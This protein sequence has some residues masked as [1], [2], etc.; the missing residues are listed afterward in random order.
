MFQSALL[1]KAVPPPLPLASEHVLPL[2]ILSTPPLLNRF[3]LEAQI[4]C[5]ATGVVYRA[6]DLKEGTLSAVKLLLPRAQS[7]EQLRQR[8]ENEARIVAQ[9]SHPNIVSVKSFHVDSS[10]RLFLVM[11]LLQGEDLDSY[12]RRRG[13]L[14]LSEVLQILTQAARGLNAAH[15]LDVVH[16]EAL[17]GRSD[18]S[19]FQ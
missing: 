12:L 8:F 18:G 5:G 19:A 10:D 7:D 13:R 3:R 17:S 2:P 15:Q 6:T 14:P 9:L 16:R 11:E 4:G 1:A